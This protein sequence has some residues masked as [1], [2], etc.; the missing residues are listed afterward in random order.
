MT[1]PGPILPANIFMD[2]KDCS[3]RSNLKKQLSFSGNISKKD[4]K[5]S[6]RV[7]PMVPSW[8]RKHEAGNRFY[9]ILAQK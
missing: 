8:G 7:P 6:L 2:E 5:D 4:L 1:S 3:V 9:K